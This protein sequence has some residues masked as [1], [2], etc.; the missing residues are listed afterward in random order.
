MNTELNEQKD[1][2]FLLSTMDAQV[3]ATEYCRLNPG[4]DIGNMIGWFAN[5]I[6]V[7]FDEANRRNQAK[8]DALLTQNTIT[9]V[10]QDVI[11]ALRGSGFDVRGETAD[12]IVYGTVHHG[13]L[14][15]DAAIQTFWNKSGCDE[16]FDINVP[17]FCGVEVPGDR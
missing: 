14:L 6:M 13:A 7:G 1:P 11:D 9:T 4:A 2:N 17:P 10:E 16:H 5:A 15:I 8:R 12:A 3:W